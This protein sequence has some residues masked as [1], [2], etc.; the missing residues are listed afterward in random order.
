MDSVKEKRYTPEIL[1]IIFAGS[2]ARG[3]LF[4]K[5]WICIYGHDDNE[6]VSL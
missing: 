2:P 3:H 5:R 1:N 6:Q 4:E